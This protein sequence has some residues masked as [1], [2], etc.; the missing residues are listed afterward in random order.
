MLLKQNN[1][2]E[3]QVQCT[4]SVLYIYLLPIIVMICPKKKTQT[5]NKI[6]FSSIIQEKLC[7]SDLTKSQRQQE[8]IEK[9]IKIS[10]IVLQMIV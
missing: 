4:V 8:F 10:V 1:D 3:S 6:L 7:F 9:K 5:L 2:H